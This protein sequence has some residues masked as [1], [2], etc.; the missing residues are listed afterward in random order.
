MT[1]VSFS[2]FCYANISPGTETRNA[3]ACQ[4]TRS[5][6]PNALDPVSGQRAAASRQ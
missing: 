1:G 3:E 5:N 2:L 4:K 6:V